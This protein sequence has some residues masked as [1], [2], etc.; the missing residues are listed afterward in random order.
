MTQTNELG[1]RKLGPLLLS[2]AIPAI[3]AMLV[4]L[5]YNIVDRI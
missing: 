4:S 2:L 3:I 1:T 5:L